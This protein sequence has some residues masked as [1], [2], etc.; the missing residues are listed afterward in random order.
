MALFKKKKK[1]EEGQVEETP[2]TARKREIEDLMQRYKEKLK[3]ELETTSP[4]ATEIELKPIPSIE[5][6]QFKSAYLPKRLNWYEK[7]CSLAERILRITPD[8]KKTAGYEEAI[9]IS[10]LEITPAGA[11]SFA[12][13]FPV[14]F[15]VLGSLVSFFLLQSNFF[16]A[17]FLIIGLSL[18]LPLAKLPFFIANGWRMKASNQM[19]LCI[20]YLVTYMRH[21]SNLERAVEFASTHLTPP[22]SLDLKK[23]LWN[24]ETGRYDTIKE[25]LDMYLN[26][27]RRWNL[28][29]IEAMHLIESS[30]YEPS[31][32]SR[33]GLLD[34]S[35]NVILEETY[36]KMLHYAQNLKGPITM[37]HMLGIIL[38]ILGLVIL[39]LVVSFMCG[40]QWY[41]LA[42]LYNIA[43][44]V[45]LYYLGKSILSKRPTGYGDTDIAEQNPELKKYRNFIIHLG[46]AE[47]KVKPLFIALFV[48]CS[49]VLFGFLP[50]LLH[51]FNP[52]WDMILTT[53]NDVKTIYSYTD[54]DASYYFLEYKESKGCPPGEGN[55]GTILGPYGLGATLFSL[56]VILGAAAGIGLYCKLKSQNVIKIRARA[57]QLEQEFASA[58]FQLGNRLG[59]GLP[60]EI[61]FGRVAEV[62]EGTMSG[63]FFNIVSSNISRLGMSVEQ[64]IFDPQHGAIVYYPSPVIDSSMKVLVESAKKG[65]RIAAQALLNVSRYIKEIHRVDERL[66]DLMS[67][68]ISSLQS[69]IKFLTPAI[70]GIV[71]GLTSM[72]TTI[73]GK[74]SGQ[75]ARLE[76]PQAG[77]GLADVTS[78]F[79]DGIPAY[80]FQI[81]VGIYVVQIVY[82]MTILV[83]GIEN[84]E[85]K[86]NERFLLGVNTLKSSF[87]YVLIAMV[88]IMLFN[89]IAASILGTI[90]GF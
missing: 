5:Y 16:L 32:E 34:K 85:D 11:V 1:G 15:M 40:V 22:L 21:T 70:A 76:S 64:A 28:E 55:V 74:L 20:F 65:P 14:L 59:D 68:I 10:H 42:A 17:F 27:W 87:I 2:A 38:P 66:K 26:T 73:L 18:I 72:I 41:H 84:G 24:V 83:N 58:L 71:I 7:G 39:P 80:F 77:A 9:D 67:D 81:V 90:G 69:Q 4:I 54:Q 37:L 19:V 88:V 48:G 49:L 12:I 45:G 82:I 50:I 53:E 47:I 25:S 60:A 62:M 46:K 79:S 8:Q 36:E 61:A 89:I 13:I 33:I 23:V 52:G 35:L 3:E 78:L 43:L 6:Q 44:P 57:K 86:L 75:L 29:F 51:W 30:L 63:N 31:E 56:L